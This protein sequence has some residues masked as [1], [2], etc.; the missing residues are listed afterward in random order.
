MED[1]VVQQHIHPF[2]SQE[3]FRLRI[4]KHEIAYAESF[5]TRATIR[6]A[7]Q[8]SQRELLVEGVVYRFENVPTAYTL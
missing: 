3:P 4:P 2:P 5:F 6:N 7:P 1:R 8:L